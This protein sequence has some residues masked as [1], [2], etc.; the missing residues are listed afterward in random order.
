MEGSKES[1]PAPHIVFFGKQYPFSHECIC[2]ADGVA[3]H[4]PSF[5]RV[6]ASLTMICDGMA[7]AFLHK[8]KSA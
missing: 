2:N 6:T 5:L 4:S 7:V 8:R 1:R 3:F